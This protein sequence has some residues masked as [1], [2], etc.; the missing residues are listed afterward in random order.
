MS[1]IIIHRDHVVMPADARLDVL[2]PHAKRL[3]HNGQEFVVVPHKLDEVKVLRN[4]GY[5]VKPPILTS[6]DWCNT[7]PFDA[8]RVTAAM[9]TLNP[10]CFVLN[11][12]ATGKTRSVLFAFDYLRRTGQARK[13]LVVSPMTSL[14][15]TWEKEVFMVMPYLK[16]GILKGSKA[17]RLEVLATDCDI[18]VINHDGVAVIEDELKARN[19]IDMMVLDEISDVYRDARSKRSQ[20]IQRVSRTIPR[21]V[22]MTAT[23]MSGQPTDVYGQVK[24]VDPGRQMLSFTRLREQLMR[25]IT[26]FKWVN[27][28]DALEQVYQIMQ[29]AV[30]F[31]RDECYDLPPSQTVIV[32]AELTAEQKE[33][34]S[35]VAGECAAEMAAGSFKAVNEADR[36]NKL[37]QISLG[38]VYN[39]EREV[40]RL[41]CGPR[42]HV[43]EEL[44]AQ[45]PSKTI[46][47]TPY[48]GSIA[49]LKE[50][51]GKRWSVAEISGDVPDAERERVFTAFQQMEHPHIIVAHP[52]TMSH[53]LTLTAASTIVWYGPPPSLERFEQANGR[54]GR[55]GQQ[56]KQLIACVAAT[57]LEERV[58]DRMKSRASTQGL[59][60]EMY[61]NQ[62]LG[63]LL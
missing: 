32:P 61:A 53:S 40:V 45:S 33:L 3:N 25:K 13:L 49:L 34:Y 55:A 1:N 60:L 11:G 20:C 62:D 42:L 38:A 58:Y 57:K 22:G 17:K 56:H 46:V 36:I 9:V 2:I 29:P 30:R 7:V 47:F 50:H 35:R 16:V 10:R 4:L 19:D 52:K 27:R 23:P 8:Q 26:A 21:V 54:I 44:C 15:Q 14:R 18:Y 5:D 63:D 6:Y 12:I 51:L 48:K 41:P 28:D 31:T 24:S 43:V 39:T 59:L 37:T